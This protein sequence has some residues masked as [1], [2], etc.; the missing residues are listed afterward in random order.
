[1]KNYPGGRPKRKLKIA[2]SAYYEELVYDNF[3]F[4]NRQG[5]L[6]HNLLAPLVELFEFGQANNIEFVGLTSKNY[7]KLDCKYDAWMFLDYPKENDF[8]NQVFEKDIKKILL[9]S[10]PKIIRP[11]NW[12]PSNHCK[13]DAVFTWDDDLVDNGKFQKLFLPI[14]LDEQSCNIA[15]ERLNENLLVQISSAKI[16]EAPGELYSQRINAINYFTNRFPG[17]FRFFGKG[18]PEFTSYGGEIKNKLQVLGKFKFS[19]VFENSMA[20]NGYITE[21][22]L[23]CFLCGVI[24]IYWGAPN[25]SRWIPKECYIDFA[26]FDHNFHRI[27]DYI[28]EM[29]DHECQN[30]RNQ[31]EDFLNS[32]GIYPFSVDNFIQKVTCKLVELC[33]KKVDLGICIPV[34]NSEKY[35]EECINSVLANA[36]GLEGIEIDVVIVDN[37]SNDE[38]YEKISSCSDKNEDIRYYRQSRNWGSRINWESVVAI[39]N[40]NYVLILCSDDFFLPKFLSR[41]S[42]FIHEDVDVIYSRL[43]FVN[44]NSLPIQISEHSGYPEPADSECRGEFKYLIGR[45]NFLTP[46]ATVF[47]KK[48]W[49]LIGEEPRLKVAG[50]W[51]LALTISLQTSNFKF[52]N[53][54]YVCYRIHGEQD[55]AKNLNTNAFLSDHI[56]IL[57]YLIVNYIDA[58]DFDTSQDALNLLSTRFKHSN[59]LTINSTINVPKLQHVVETLKRLA[60]IG[61][62]Q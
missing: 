32:P 15:D 39:N 57:D 13:F 46:S 23:D 27:A 49:T 18:W 61:G 19:L 44:E 8:Y 33:E 11:Q 9:I 41:I 37:C 16:S 10:E 4:K 1:M 12:Y 60:G 5:P 2:V 58:F 14:S 40:A 7:E 36:I 26:D 34:Y 3:C 45:D 54:P 29:S 42:R 52:I 55:T 35:I 51:L 62:K 30:F 21:K 20:Q 6:G 53:L 48:Y 22:I 25:I 47:K 31:I 43:L 59:L 38:S 24:P 50:D 56:E 28:E 17:R